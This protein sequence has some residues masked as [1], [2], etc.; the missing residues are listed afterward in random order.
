MGILKTE[1][2]EGHTP[3]HTLVTIISEGRSLKHLADTVHSPLL[4]AKPDWGV[5][6]DTDY[7]QGIHTRLRV[8]ENCYKEHTLI[9]AGHLPYPGLGYIGKEK[10][11]QWVPFSYASPED[12][13][14]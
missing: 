12:I 4:I 7:Q 8:L 13:N 6:W 11:Y 14:I 2:A 1:L 10:D 5:L 3:G 9:F